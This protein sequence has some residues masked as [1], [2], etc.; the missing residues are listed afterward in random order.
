MRSN[1]LVTSGVF[2][3]LIVGLL[4]APSNSYGESGELTYFT[5]DS[6]VS[7]PEASN[8]ADVCGCQ[9]CECCLESC[10]PLWTVN[11]GTLILHRSTPQ[12]SVLV[13]TSPSRGSMT[14]LDASD[15]TFGWDAG[16]DIGVTRRVDKYEAFDAIEFRY[17]G[18]Q[19]W[20]ANTSI[21][22]GPRWGFPNIPGYFSDSAQIDASY[23]SQLHSAELNL[24]RDS[25]WNRLTWLAGM[26]WIGLDERLNLAESFIGSSMN[27]TFTTHNNLFG[28][29][30]GAALKL[31]ENGGPLHI[32]CVSKAGLYD[33]STSNRY[34]DDDS[35][36]NYNLLCSDRKHQVAFAGDI[37]LTATYQW[38]KHVAL[39]GGYQLLWIQG[40]AIAGDQAQA[41]NYT[42]HD[43]IASNG[44]VFYHGA[45]ASVNITW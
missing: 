18:I 40:A 10:R 8:A 34:E 42:A 23:R 3:S 13:L 36:G 11:A 37:G 12:P 6:K 43:G 9:S 33:N 21:I 38:T 2:F 27:H 17:F 39:Q 5:G 32:N 19:D 4:C 26:R 20:Q 30:I 35:W 15:F 44:G 22:T 7:P 28:G 31:W 29:Q 14:L 45:M 1:Y 25:S 41:I 24:Q 16:V